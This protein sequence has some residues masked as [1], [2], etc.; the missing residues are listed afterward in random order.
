MS[1]MTHD[2]AV[3]LLGAYAL[4]AV[5]PDEAQAI[6]DHLRDCPRCR[7]ELAEHRETASLLAHASADAPPGVWDRIAGSLEQPAP[8]VPYMASPRH[9]T[10][11]P[12]PA[13]V[14]AAAALVVI[15]ALG[16]QVRDQ[17]QRIDDL[18]SAIAAAPITDV[19]ELATT[20]GQTLPVVLLAD[21]RAQLHAARLPAL[22]RGRTYQLWGVAGSDLVSLGVLGRDPD[23]ISFQ[24]EGYTALA[25]TAER[26]PGVVQSTN[27][28]VASGALA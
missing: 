9:R 8:V 18:S 13:L 24:A 4:D 5:E 1:P 27:D 14:A 28:P 20:D 22:G 11:R 17:R 16:L 15:G 6:D 3:E 21:G 10:R 26:A 7:G 12:I 2:E 25:V 19:V 23:V